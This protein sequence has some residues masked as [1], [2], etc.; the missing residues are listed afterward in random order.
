MPTSPAALVAFVL[1]PDNCIT[2]M[3]LFT[4]MALV[5]IHV[6]VPT[7][8]RLASVNSHR[9]HSSRQSLLMFQDHLRPLSRPVFGPL[10][11]SDLSSISPSRQEAPVPRICPLF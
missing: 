7:S 5:I 8:R 2:V 6:P 3:V 9:R 4:D 1:P 11:I 10:V